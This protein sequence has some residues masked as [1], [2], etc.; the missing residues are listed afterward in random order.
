MKILWLFST[1]SM[2][3]VTNGC[4]EK[5]VPAC[6]LGGVYVFACEKTVIDAGPA[7]AVAPAGH[8]SGGERLASEL[9]LAPW[10][11]FNRLTAP[12]AGAVAGTRHWK[13]QG[14]SS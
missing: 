9:L 12:G 13:P 7:K 8:D 6:S 14:Q 1:E 2:S 3:G 4:T 11:G 5:A 10:A